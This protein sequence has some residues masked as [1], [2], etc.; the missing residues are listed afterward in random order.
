M[1]KAGLLLI[2]ML[3]GQPALSGQDQAAAMFASL[4]GSGSDSGP[5]AT[6]VLAPQEVLL[7]ISAHAIGQANADTATISVSIR[8]SARTSAA[9]QAEHDAI[10]RRVRDV[11]QAAGVA[12]ADIRPDASSELRAFDVEEPPPSEIATQAPVAVAAVPGGAQQPP[13]RVELVPPHP[14]PS[15][16]SNIEIVLRDAAK[17]DTLLAAIRQAGGATYGRPRFTLS[18]DTQVR[19]AARAEA[20]AKARAEA[21]AY[22]SSLGMR[23]ARMVRVTERGTVDFMS[24]MLGE[25][26]GGPEGLRN[27]REP[28]G[29]KVPVLVFVGVDFV[30]APR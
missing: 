25:M 27:L 24:V 22:A 4:S 19:R 8:G 6:Q 28:S 21:D 14:E 16:N 20:L 11:A 12:P 2:G 7:E 29:G 30:L 23:V 3:T 18:D 10:L 17:V 1:V 5:V 26:T 9:A 13:I 15:V